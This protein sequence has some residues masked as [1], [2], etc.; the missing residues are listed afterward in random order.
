M[1]SDIDGEP[2][3]DA[4]TDMTQALCMLT[5]TVNL[6]TAEKGGQV[7]L[8]KSISGIG[9]GS[10]GDRGY[11]AGNRNAV[12]YRLLTEALRENPNHFNSVVAKN[13]A[14]TC[15]P[16]AEDPLLQASEDDMRWYLEHL[17]LIHI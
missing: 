8:E 15:R 6:L 12:A 14:E 3:T 10:S 2:S 5:E 17:S 9:G 7:T 4:P 11:S 1:D 13:L 16:S